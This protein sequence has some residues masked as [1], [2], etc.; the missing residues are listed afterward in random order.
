MQVKNLTGYNNLRGCPRILVGTLYCG[1]QD[2]PHCQKSI[3]SQSGVE[4]EHFVISNRPN[5]EAHEALY[6]KFMDK[7]HDFDLFVKVDSDMVICRSDLFKRLASCFEDKSAIDMITVPVRD[8]FTGCEIAGLNAFRSSVTWDE[9]RDRIFVDNEPVPRDKTYIAKELAPAA[10]HCFYCSEFHAFHFGV[11]RG[12]KMR[13]ALT[14]KSRKYRSRFHILNYR[15]VCANTY[16]NKSDRR[17]W[18]ACIGLENALA[19]V[20]DVSHV[21]YTDQRL[22]SYFSLNLKNKD[23]VELSRYAAALKRRSILNPIRWVY[24][25]EA[26]WIDIKHMI[27]NTYH[28]LRV[29]THA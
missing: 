29:G 26:A 13:A 23:V 24:W 4:V 11:H 22:D 8:F 25:K 6:S 27:R 28:K 15:K 9:A 17:L 21:S 3:E 18:L 19:G 7:A 12:V 1:E 5:K 14:T 2:Y 16:K 10:D 20:F